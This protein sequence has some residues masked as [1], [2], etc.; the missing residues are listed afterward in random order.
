M[1]KTKE[2]LLRLEDARGEYGDDFLDDEYFY[3][4]YL[5]ETPKD[6]DEKLGIIK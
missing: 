2:I 6:F 3:N 5:R 1:S 4:K